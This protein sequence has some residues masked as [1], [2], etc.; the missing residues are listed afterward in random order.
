MTDQKFSF[1]EALL[2]PEKFYSDPTQVSADVR[3]SQ[4]QKREILLAWKA[5]EQALIIA[6]GEG[7][8]GGERP[9]LKTVLL[10]LEKMEK[11]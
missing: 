1:E 9:H 2:D 11:P 5:N 8:E 3:W 4:D 6:A 10:E 7:L